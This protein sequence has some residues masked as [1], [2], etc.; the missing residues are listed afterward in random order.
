[1]LHSAQSWPAY[2]LIRDRLFKSAW[3]L[4]LIIV[5]GTAAVHGQVV[6]ES[7]A[8]TTIASGTAAIAIPMGYGPGSAANSV[9]PIAVTTAFK[10][11]R[12][13]NRADSQSFTG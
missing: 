6:L 8:F 1:M 10:E 7:D 11:R 9:M 5:L 4:L 12:Y 2:A 3:L 13:F